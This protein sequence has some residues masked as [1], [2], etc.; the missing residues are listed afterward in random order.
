MDKQS[1]E[2]RTELK[3]TEHFSYFYLSYKLIGTEKK[4]QLDHQLRPPQSTPIPV[5]TIRITK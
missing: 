2:D 1:A 4:N 5:F 3:G